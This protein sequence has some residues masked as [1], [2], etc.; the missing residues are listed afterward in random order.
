M[1]GSMVRCDSCTLWVDVELKDM[2][3]VI[4]KAE[5]GSHP[6]RL[7][8]LKL[9]SDLLPRPLPKAW[10]QYGSGF[11]NRRGLYGQWLNIGPAVDPFFQG[12]FIV[13]YTDLFG[14]ITDT[15]DLENASTK[16]NPPAP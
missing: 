2:Y 4:D 14:S 1:G 10:Q 8:V 15:Y 16:H 6:A 11:G 12:N 3:V 5:K 9:L 13:I 7:R